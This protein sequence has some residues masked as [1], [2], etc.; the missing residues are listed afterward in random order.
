MSAY[1]ELDDEHRR[2]DE[3]RESESRLDRLCSATLC[4]LFGHRRWFFFALDRPDGEGL[5][6]CMRCRAYSLNGCSLAEAREQF[7]AFDRMLARES[8]L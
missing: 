2:S 7:A 3:V 5:W 6:V 4:R 8:L 1:R